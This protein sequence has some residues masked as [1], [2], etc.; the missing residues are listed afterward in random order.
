MRALLASKLLWDKRFS[1]EN[2]LLY[3][4]SLKLQ[5]DCSDGVRS[6]RDDLSWLLCCCLS[7]LANAISSIAVGVIGPRP[8]VEVEQDLQL[9]LQEGH[10]VDIAEFFDFAVGSRN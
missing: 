10:T 6:S 4:V 2:L 7:G 8:R 5:Q 3:F 1:L 9:E